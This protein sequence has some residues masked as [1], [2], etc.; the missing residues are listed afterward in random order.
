MH[1]DTVEKL[2]PEMFVRKGTGATPEKDALLPALN[3]PYKAAGFVD[4]EVS[5]LVLIMGK[6]GF[7]PGG[8]AYHFLQYVHMGVGEFGFSPDGQCFRV[9]FSDIQ[10]K[11]V[12]LHGRNLL[13]TCDYIALRRMQWIRQADRD[14][15]AGDGVRDDEPII[16][17][18]EV[19]NW[20]RLA[21]G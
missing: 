20:L 2:S 9:V 7:K 6:D 13:R 10:P 11:L 3:D 21:N 16:T 17:R 12:T 4:N 19:T 18:I 14:F 8:T 1:G 5:R 15:R